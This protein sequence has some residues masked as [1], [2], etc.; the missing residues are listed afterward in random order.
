MS[1]IC[2][3]FNKLLKDRSTSILIM[4]LACTHQLHIYEIF[5]YEMT[6]SSLTLALACTDRGRIACC[7][8]TNN[9]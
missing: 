1:L 8:H 9:S 5:E 6:S 4:A 3:V 7:L 2:F